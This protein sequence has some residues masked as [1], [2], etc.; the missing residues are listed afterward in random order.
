MELAELMVERGSRKS[1]HALVEFAESFIAQINDSEDRI[2][3]QDAEAERR[4]SPWRT[5]TR[6]IAEII[7]GLM[8]EFE[9]FLF[10]SR[11]RSEI[12]SICIGQPGE[13]YLDLPPGPM[14]RYW[15]DDTVGIYVN[16][17]DFDAVT[18]VHTNVCA[19][20]MGLFVIAS[21]ASIAERMEDEFRAEADE[22]D[23][24]YIFEDE[25]GDA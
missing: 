8:L 4:G 5:T 22:E 1:W 12:F 2:Y 16:A 24:D 10:G 13:G 18:L 7:K 25:D 15:G 19:E 20:L 6:D 9:K 21:P 23:Q 11:T 3:E 14:R 17:G